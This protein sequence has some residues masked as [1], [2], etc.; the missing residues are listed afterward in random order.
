MMS[1]PVRSPSLIKDGNRIFK[2]IFLQIDLGYY[3]L[4][5]NRECFE[6]RSLPLDHKTLFWPLWDAVIY[7]NT[8]IC[9]KK[10][11]EIPVFIFD[12]HQQFHGSNLLQDCSSR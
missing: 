1:S 5:L 6:D 4:L 11:P 2:R 12:P 10:I 9:N 7:E 3:L 8:S